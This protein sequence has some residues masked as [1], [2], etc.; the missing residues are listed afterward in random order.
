MN[1]TTITTIS[2][3]KASKSAQY[4]Q[5]WIGTQVMFTTWEGQKI[6]GTITRWAQ[7]HPIATFSDGTWAR[8]DSQVEVVNV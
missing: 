4:R 6:Q 5:G 7:Y 8:L 2:T 3:A 1:S